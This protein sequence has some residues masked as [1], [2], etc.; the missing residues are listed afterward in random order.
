MPETLTPS[1]ETEESSSPSEPIK[2]TET[3]PPTKPDLKYDESRKE[4]IVLIDEGDEIVEKR[5]PFQEFLYGLREWGVK[6][7]TSEW[8][9]LQ[10]LLAAG[11]VQSLDEL[12]IVSRAVLVKD[13]V[14]FPQF[15]TVFGQMFYGIK[16]PT[17][18]DYYEEKKEPTAHEQKEKEN[19]EEVV[20][21]TFLSSESVH[22]GEEATKDIKGSPNPADNGENKDNKGAEAGQ[23]GSE[24][25]GEDEGGEKKGKLKTR[26]RGGKEGH[27]STRQT[28]E[29]RRYDFL[30]K[31]RPLNYEQFGRALA[32]LRTIVQETTTTRTKQLDAY[33]TVKSIAQHSGSP[34]L[35]WKEEVEEK[36][37]VVIMSDVGG[38]IDRFRPI[39][40]KLFSASKD[41]LEGVEIYY[42][43]NVIYDN[44]WPQKDGSWG[45][46]FIPIGDILK[47][48]PSTKV[49]M[50][51]DAWMA[52][53]EYN[54]TSAEVSFQ[55][56]KDRFDSVVWINPIPEKEQSK[57][58]DSG[59]IAAIRNVFSMHD[60]TLAGIE[61][62]VT[63][64]MREQ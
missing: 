8:L 52:N 2:S 16:P 35:L 49:I 11:E 42:F 26:G 14:H 15:D 56:I 64:L 9:D 6:V 57:W 60:L 4:I 55:H 18:E 29:E 12:Y 31:D 34:E 1:F 43:H 5:H 51:G 41:F 33:A 38:T 28:I 27:P 44:V 61:K 3:T 32:K 24:G 17:D 36:P 59:T 13:A 37:S 53:F 21:A 19:I 20:E 22:G 58:D 54:G 50:V 23:A 39:L 48:D 10:A 63:E 25:G 7:S 47:K 62:A 40:E 45:R 46:H 30:R